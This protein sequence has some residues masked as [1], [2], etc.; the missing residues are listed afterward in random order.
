[1]L[2]GA[3]TVVQG[4]A[5]IARGVAAPASYWFVLGLITFV[6]LKSVIK[7]EATGTRLVFVV[8]VIGIAFGCASL[9]ERLLRNYVPSDIQPNDAND[10]WPRWDTHMSEPIVHRRSDQVPY[11]YVVLPRPS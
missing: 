5:N 4:L 7:I 1:V 2:S 3:R 8:V 9:V 11:S 6:G 10:I